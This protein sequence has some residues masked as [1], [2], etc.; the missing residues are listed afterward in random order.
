M[1][2][3]FLFLLFT[4]YISCL[5]PGKLPSG[6]ERVYR[7]NRKNPENDVKQ[8]TPTMA[9]FIS[10]HW[11]NNIIQHTEICEEDII[12][13]EKI[14]NFKQYIQDQFTHYNDFKVE[15]LAWTPQGITEDIL[16]LIVLE[17]YNEKNVLKTLINSPFWESKQIS[18]ECL[19]E[20][21]TRYSSTK[22]KVLDIDS[23]LNNNVRYKLLWK[24]FKAEMI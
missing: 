8:I 3:R 23:F 5:T 17:Q 13:L 1:K 21:V 4:P 15:Y 14:N 10:R 12:I 19:L 16:F 22:D 6:K 20:S 24:D 18:S 9:S 11:L 7:Y 2:L